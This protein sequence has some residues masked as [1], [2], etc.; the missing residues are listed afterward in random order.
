[1][2]D[3]T[4][5]VV[6][7]LE[8][9]APANEAQ[10]ADVM[11]AIEAAWQLAEAGNVRVAIESDWPAARLRDAIGECHMPAVGVCYD[12]GNAV[13]FGLDAAADIPALGALMTAVHVKDRLRTGESVALGT[14]DADLA[15]AF[16][17]LAA[18]GY[19]GTAVLETP[20]GAHP[21]DSA[22]HN[23]SV[24]QA[25]LPRGAAARS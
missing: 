20:V 1:M 9:N 25:L 12:I 2:L 13:A 17:A 23:L 11:C 24:V 4:I 3:S 7:L 22:A 16:A 19:A 18:I 8:A 14:G 6:P 21:L 10:F 15:G 5:M